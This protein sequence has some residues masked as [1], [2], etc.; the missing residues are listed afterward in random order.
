[1]DSSPTLTAPLTIQQKINGSLFAGACAGLAVDVTLFPL[2]TIKTR[3]QSA[4]GFR[5]SGGFRKLY[6]GLAPVVVGSI[7]GGALFFALYEGV[8]AQLETMHVK[9]KLYIE[10]L[11]DGSSKTAQDIKDEYNLS[12][13][14]LFHSIAAGTVGECTACMIR[15]PIELLKQRLQ[16]NP[17]V[18]TQGRFSF[19]LVRELNELWTTSANR[20]PFQLLRVFFRGYPITIAREVPFAM[21]QMPLFEGLKMYA[22][23]IVAV[24]SSAGVLSAPPSTTEKYSTRSAVDIAC[25]GAISGGCSAFLT[26]PMDVIKT[27]I[28]TERAASVL[29]HEASNG[30]VGPHRPHVGAIAHTAR[31]ASGVWQKEGVMGFF[32]GGGTRAM[33]IALGGAIFFNTF[34]SLKGF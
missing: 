32:K 23:R 28:M 14:F 34:E 7:P 26:T 8:K 19:A 3:I 2:D 12:S 20:S 13:S 25:F 10:S 6:S 18:S 9:R 29:H 16:T 24:P 1:M 27:R 11:K 33:W 5:K 21:I 15:V 22:P 17:H 4:D 31:I 30:S